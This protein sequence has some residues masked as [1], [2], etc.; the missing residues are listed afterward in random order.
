MIKSQLPKLLAGRTECR[1]LQTTSW[2]WRCHIY[3]LANRLHFRLSCH[4][5]PTTS[6]KPSQFSGSQ[7]FTP[8][9]IKVLM[10]HQCETFTPHSGHICLEACICQ[11]GTKSEKPSLRASP[12]FES[13]FLAGTG[14]L[15]FGFIACRTAPVG[16]AAPSALACM[17]A[18]A[19]YNS[20]SP[21]AVHHSA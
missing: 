1:L 17:I 14:E 6:W 21:S 8:S 15:V 7:V 9:Q 10:M 4:A 13:D 5:A 2:P 19:T 12:S 3:V 20:W 16:L 11:F 18:Q